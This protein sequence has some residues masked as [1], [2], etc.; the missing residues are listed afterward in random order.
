MIYSLVQRSPQFESDQCFVA[1]NATLIGDVAL[2]KDVSVWFNTVIR[3]DDDQIRIGRGSNIQD[4]AVLHVDPGVPMD[5]GE[6]VTV[7][8]Q[9]ML[10][11]CRI[12]DHS[13]VGIN[14]V[15]LNGAKI[16]RHCLI[17]ANALIPEGMEVPD[18]SLV[19]GSPGKVRRE[20]TQSEMVGI[21]DN[22]RHYVL[23]MQ[24]YL[25]ELKVVSGTG[26]GPL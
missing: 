22:A 26:P 11:G 1:P 18:G 20:L 15:I 25:K 3:A 14:A 7:G 16:G 17:G 10:H 8:H 4:G 21:E 9:A 24:R 12:G 23:Q 6:G 2:A 5:I 19:L 13:L